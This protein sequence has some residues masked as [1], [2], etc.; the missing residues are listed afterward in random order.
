MTPFEQWLT[1]HV[2]P[3][4]WHLATWAEDTIELTIL[5]LFLLGLSVFIVCVTNKIRR[6]L[7]K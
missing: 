4:S 6:R 1:E 3:Y 5:F 2:P 7:G